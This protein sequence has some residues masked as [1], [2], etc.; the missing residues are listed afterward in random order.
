MSGIILHVIELEVCFFLK[1]DVYFILK[2]IIN[3]TVNLKP[4]HFDVR[5]VS[6]AWN[7]IPRDYELEVS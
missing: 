5:Y 6:Y 1:E 4:R 3:A 2:L 7:Q